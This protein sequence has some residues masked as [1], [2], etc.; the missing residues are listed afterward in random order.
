M[1]G[2]VDLRRTALHEAGHA[3]VMHHLGCTVTLVS[4]VPIGDEPGRT[5]GSC[6]S[7]KDFELLD[8]HDVD[9]A[10]LDRAHREIKAWRAS[11][12]ALRY[13]LFDDKI[14]GQVIKEDI[15]RS[16]RMYEMIEQHPKVMRLEILNKELCTLAYRPSVALE[17][18]RLAEVLLEERE[19]QE[20][21]FRRFLHEQP[22]GEA[23]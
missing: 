23:R 12:Y 5:K 6:L 21:R 8:K 3:V 13:F 16:L 2:M 7:S 22:G 11:C 17:I 15:E 18:A 20:C 1:G 19:I 4:I 14:I 9:D 10:L